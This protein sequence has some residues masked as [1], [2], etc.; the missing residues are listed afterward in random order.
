MTSISLL[1]RSYFVAQTDENSRSHDN[2]ANFVLHILHITIDLEQFRLTE[3]CLTVFTT[4]SVLVPTQCLL[5]GPVV[6]DSRRSDAHQHGRE[7]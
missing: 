7:K 5:R 3:H 2:L 6:G 4:V 1:R